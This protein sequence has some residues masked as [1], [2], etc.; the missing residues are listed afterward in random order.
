M[1]RLLL[2][3]Q[4]I[5]DKAVNVQKEDEIMIVN[6]NKRDKVSTVTVNKKDKV[7]VGVTWADMIKTTPT[8]KKALLKP[9][10]CLV[11]ACA[12]L[13]HLQGHAHCASRVL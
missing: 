2:W 7:N 5:L 6:E 1:I 13:V 9:T 12:F 3:R 10:H 8:Q 11:E 4:I